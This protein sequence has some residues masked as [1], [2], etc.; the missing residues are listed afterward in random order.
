[1]NASQISETKNQPTK[2]SKSQSNI[3]DL[4]DIES[5]HFS[6]QNLRFKESNKLFFTESSEK[7]YLTARYACAI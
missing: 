4:I 6:H 3:I 2:F 1:M 7:P 5:N